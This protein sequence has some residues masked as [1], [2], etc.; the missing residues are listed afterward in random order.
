MILGEK[1]TELR[2]RSGL[3]QEEFGARIGVSR[4][5]VSK[6]EMAQTT[7]DLNKI[8]AISQFFEVSTDFLLKDEYDLSFLDAEKNT[9]IQVPKADALV[10]ETDTPKPG[11]IELKEIQDYLSVKKNA[12]CRF[13][14]AIFLL[15]LSPITGIFISTFNEKLFV[16]GLL[17]QLIMLIIAVVILIMAFWNLSKYKRLW[18]EDLELAYGVH[19]FIVE[20][21]KGFEHTFLVGIILGVV[22]ILASVVPMMVVSGFTNTNNLAIAIGGSIM[23]LIFAFGISCMTY[24]LTINHGYK[25]VLRIR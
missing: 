24:V 1:I 21:R 20:L 16:V 2:K 11:M 6:W 14:I 12:A 10:E 13:V 5:A 18:R 8:M 23:L 15:F 7:P 3:S 17:I 19:G 22:S 9:G 25:R 4:Q